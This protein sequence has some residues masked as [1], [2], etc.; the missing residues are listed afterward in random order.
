[1]YTMIC[2]MIICNAAVINKYRP[3]YT[4]RYYISMGYTN[5]S[6]QRHS[7]IQTYII[8][9]PYISYVLCTVI[10]YHSYHMANNPI[11]H[12]SYMNINL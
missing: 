5:I 8:L 7:D 9:S 3:M 4:M 12:I 6:E 1:M 11:P 2:T 10:L